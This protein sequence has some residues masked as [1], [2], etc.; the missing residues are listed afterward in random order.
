MILP[1]IAQCSYAIIKRAAFA[2]SF[3]LIHRYLHALNICPVPER[4]KEPV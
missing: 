2:D 3:F 1:D 4:L